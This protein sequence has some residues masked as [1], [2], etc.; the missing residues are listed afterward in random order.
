MRIGERI[1]VKMSHF[2]RVVF[3]LFISLLDLSAAFHLYLPTVNKK[4]LIEAYSIT[5]GCFNAM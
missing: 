1:V 3:L 5:E 4:A 2:W